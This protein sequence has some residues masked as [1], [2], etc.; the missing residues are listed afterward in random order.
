MIKEK[1]T[2]LLLSP[3]FGGIT[4]IGDTHKLPN[5]MKIKQNISQT[6]NYEK[7]TTIKMFI[8]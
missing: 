6:Y 2:Q 7:I 8:F 3:L 1:Y 4:T 5:I